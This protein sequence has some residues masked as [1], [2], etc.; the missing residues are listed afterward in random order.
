[1]HS[2]SIHDQFYLNNL[3]D[4]DRNR[5]LSCLLL[6]S[7][8]RI[9]LAILYGFN[10]ELIRIRE[11][12]SNQLA[13]EIRLQWWKGIFES[14]GNGFLSKSTS[15]FVDKLLSIICQYNLPYHNF[16]DMIEARFFDIYSEPM[17]D[18][19]HLESYAVKV[20]SYLIN[21]AI[22]ILD[23]KQHRCDHELIKHAGIAQLIAELLMILSKHN[24]RGQLYLPLDILGAAGLDRESFLF[25]KDKE[26]ISIAI[27][28]FAE[29]GLEHLLKAR[30]LSKNIAK[31]IFPAFVP[32]SITGNILENA[33]DIGIKIFDHP[34]KIHQCILQL[35]ILSAFI[36]KRF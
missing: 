20:S 25:G 8:I 1:M 23:G 17:C 13:G 6:P 27:K 22:M 33:C 36:K 34:Y 30:K 5:Y 7:D 32:M 4:M 31:N 12:T 3:R 10:S 26:K 29:L 2:D 15:P 11:V 28:I 14:F 9:P 24:S 19:E 21:L 16:I 18:C 35:Y